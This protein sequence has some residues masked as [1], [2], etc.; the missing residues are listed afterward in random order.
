MNSHDEFTVLYD[1]QRDKMPS[2]SIDSVVPAISSVSKPKRLNDRSK[3]RIQREPQRRC[4]VC[5]APA[6]C[7]HFNT[8]SCES[9]AA[10]FRRTV[11]CRH[12]YTCSHNK[13]C[14]IIESDGRTLCKFCRFKSCI[15]KGMN[16]GAVVS[17]KLPLIPNL[18]G[19]SLLWR[20]VVAQRSTYLSRYQSLIRSYGG[21]QAI[22]K[23]GVENPTCLHIS[24]AVASEVPVLLEYLK[25]TG[26]KEIAKH[27][28]DFQQLSKA[29]FYPWLCFTVVMHNLRNSGHRRNVAFVV[30]ESFIKV[31]WETVGLMISSCHGLR[32]CQTVLDYTM[33]YYTTCLEMAS[34]LHSLHFEDFEHSAIFHIFAL[35]LT[36]KI[37]KNNSSVRSQ[38]SD[39]F[40]Q[41]RDYYT[42]NFNDVA[43]RLGNVVLILSE[44]ERLVTA[45][46]DYAMILELNG[47]VPVV[48]R[49]LGC[50]AQLAELLGEFQA[51][52]NPQQQ[53]IELLDL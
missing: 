5:G 26:F 24:I 16:I 10:F 47:H 53:L 50:S 8:I 11:S 13:T 44:M 45:F 51:N 42:A 41:L 28:D 1:N 22:T 34:R 30:D 18:P 49:T 23:M 33:R 35:Q 52:K 19:D 31:N 29:L 15:R 27:E 40:E 25:V 39:V 2:G 48:A 21:N 6:F 43:V 9:C 46:K 38:L 12:R 37:L 36:S 7:K 32:N 17:S 3:T 14:D 4:V 20:V